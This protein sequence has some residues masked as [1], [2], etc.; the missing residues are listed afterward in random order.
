MKVDQRQ[1]LDTVHPSLGLKWRECRIQDLGLLQ[2]NKSGIRNKKDRSQKGGV[3]ECH[4]HLQMLKGGNRVALNQLNVSM[5]Y[6]P[7][8][9]FQYQLQ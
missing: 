8:L 2:M 1:E 6:L 3:M 4:L 7:L 9:P 5:G